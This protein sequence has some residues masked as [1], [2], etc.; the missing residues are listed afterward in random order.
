MDSLF[1][2]DRLIT[3]TAGNKDCI[4]IIT[5]G[6]REC[7]GDKAQKVRSRYVVAGRF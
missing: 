7:T 2:V 3:R 1:A 4:L 5:I 6:Q